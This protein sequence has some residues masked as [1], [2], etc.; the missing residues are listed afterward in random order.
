MLTI[1]L[2]GGLGNQLF[3]IYLLL[4]EVLKNKTNFI[5]IQK[6]M[7]GTR[8]VFYWNNIFSRLK[9]NVQ[10]KQIRCIDL[11]E[12][13]FHYIP[14]PKIN[15][16]ANV[17]FNGYYQSYKYF[18]KHY[19]RINR[20]LGIDSIK[21]R[22]KTKYDYK[23]TISIHFRVGDYKSQTHC[24]PIMTKDY[25]IKS[26]KTIQNTIS[27]RQDLT[28][29]SLKVLYFGEKQ[30]KDHINTIIDELK[31]IYT[32]FEFIKV[33]DSYAD[34]EQMLI[35]SLCT[36]NCIANSTFSWWGAYFNNNPNKIVTY[37]S[38]WFGPQILK[39]K[40]KQNLNDLFPNNWI[41]IEN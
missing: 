20:I 29:T 26:L 10:K 21:N 40:T 17:K 32:T 24:H 30:D 39:D 14:I 22:Y 13:M 37:P 34:W 35:M 2:K 3:Q 5:L 27:D 11:K 4:T 28:D 7:P 1:E 9:N 12:Q 19:N 18:E 8:Q 38:L 41:K 6:R 23:N 33:S 16:K 36:H 25:Y 15:R 31:A